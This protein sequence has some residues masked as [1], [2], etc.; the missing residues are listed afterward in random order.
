MLNQN[1]NIKNQNGNAK[2][3][4][5]KKVKSKLISLFA[6]FHFDFCILIFPSFL[7]L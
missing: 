3:K 1:V 4:K 5:D 2:F 6:I 7:A